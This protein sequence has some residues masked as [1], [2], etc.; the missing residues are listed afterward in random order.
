MAMIPFVTFV[1]NEDRLQQFLMEKGVFYRRDAYIECIGGSRMY[2]EDGS[3]GLHWGC[4]GVLDQ[5]IHR[6]YC[7]LEDP[8]T[9]FSIGGGGYS[10]FMV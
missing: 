9:Y 10:V 4:N 5:R 8:N 2:L 3:R 6:R 1:S 7:S